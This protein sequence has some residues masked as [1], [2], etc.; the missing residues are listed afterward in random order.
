M[1]V[2]EAVYME[3][4]SDPVW[5]YIAFINLAAQLWTSVFLYRYQSAQ[6]SSL[7]QIAILAAYGYSIYNFGLVGLLTCIIMYVT[8]LLLCNRIVIYTMKRD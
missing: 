2:M 4:V 8:L 5:K 1:I 6:I 3:F 7:G